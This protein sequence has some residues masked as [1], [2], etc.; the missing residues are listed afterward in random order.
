[1]KR[2]RI[3]WMALALVAAVAI[4]ASD[5]G[6]SAIARAQQT[7]SP[8]HYDEL[9]FPELPEVTLPD[10]ERF[11]L[12]NGLRVILIEDRELPL[13][14]GSLRVRVGSRWEP[15][16]KVGLASLTGSVLRSGGTETL[17]PGELN[18]FLENRAAAIETSIGTSAGTVSFSALRE[19]LDAVLALFADVARRPA[20]DPQQFEL[21]KN[22]VRGSIARRNDDSGSIA[23][24]EFNKLLYGEGSP[25]ARTVEYETLDRI[26]RDDAI[27]FYRE[28]FHPERAIL[29]LVGD[30]DAAAMREKIIA[31]FGDW[32]PGG[33]DALE[34][35]AATQATLGGTYRIDL[36]Q[37][38]QST[39]R[40]GHIGGQFD[41]PDYPALSVLNEVLNGFSGRL[42][43]KIRSELG[44]AYSVYGLWRARSDYDGMFL[45]GGQ[46]RSEETVP[47]VRALRAEV[48]R[49]RREPVAAGEL[50]NAKES[51]LNSFVFN[52]QDP[53]QTLSRLMRYEYYGYPEDFIFQ[54]QRSVKATTVEDIQRVAREYLQPENLVTLV[55]G[56]SAQ[57]EPPLSQ[58]GDRVTTLDITIP[59]PA[60]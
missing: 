34:P 57:I 41:S 35:P 38:T 45:A 49:L 30:F 3:L 27:A 32:Q 18:Q 47:F 12:A 51:I 44:L 40:L 23:S 16:D 59:T 28:N 42:F 39:I 48:D 58:L 36:P 9:T 37:L 43:N 13:V 4:A 55:V 53:A 52:F 25:Y 17:P 11:E 5:F 19:D 7:G 31:T 24:R 21:A 56:N 1:M 22:Q 14:S 50:D 26:S 29:G 10:S 6:W 2:K 8:R 54:Y 20:F 60:S 46:T 33:T 15:A